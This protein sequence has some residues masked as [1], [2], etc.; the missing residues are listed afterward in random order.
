M[1]KMVIK[2]IVY[3]F[4]KLILD[5]LTIVYSTKILSLNKQTKT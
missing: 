3:I 2:K 5:I 1:K 4:Q